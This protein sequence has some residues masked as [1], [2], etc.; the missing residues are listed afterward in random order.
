MSILPNR[1]RIERRLQQFCETKCPLGGDHHA[2]VE[3]YR[4]GGP[5]CYELTGYREEGDNERETS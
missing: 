2:H 3:V 1:R 5:S 4:A